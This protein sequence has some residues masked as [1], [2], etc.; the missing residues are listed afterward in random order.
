M[1]FC[2]HPGD[3]DRLQAPPG[4]HTPSTHAE[5]AWYL[6]QRDTRRA[7]AHVALA[8]QALREVRDSPGALTERLLARLRLVEAEARWLFCEPGAFDLAGEAFERCA[9][10]GDSI[11]CGDALL[12]QAL[13]HYDNVDT[14]VRAALFER[15]GAT[16]RAAGDSDRAELVTAWQ[17]YD[18]TYLDAAA[19][20]QALL[21]LA[22]TTQASHPGVRAVSAWAQAGIRFE[23]SDV[24]AAI[25]GYQN[26]LALMDDCGFQRC[27]IT[28]MHNIGAAF[29]TLHDYAAALVWFKR[30]SERAQR[31]GWPRSEG[32]CLMG[33]GNVLRLLGRHDAALAFLTRA[34]ERLARVPP[35]RMQA[36]LQRSLGDTHV[37][38]GD[39]EQ[40][41]RSFGQAE[42]LIRGIDGHSLL[43]QTLRGKALALSQTGRAV[44]ALDAAAE[45]LRI[46]RDLGDRARQIESLCALASI[47]RTHAWPAPLGSRDAT[48]AIHHLRRAIRLAARIE[49]H[50][51]PP[52][53]LAALSRDQ[54]LAGDIAAALATERQASVARRLTASRE[55]AQSAVAMQIR[56]ETDIARADAQHQRALA[57]AE[58]E[59]VAQLNAANDLL[60]RVSQLG[61]AITRSLSTDSLLEVLTHRA[62]EL[63]PAQSVSLWVLQEAVIE[64]QVAAGAAPRRFPLDGDSAI[65][66]CVRESGTGTVQRA[67][68]LG[69][70][71]SS[72]LLAPLLNGHNLRGV[73]AIETSAC[74]AYAERDLHVAASLA[75][76]VTIALANALA[77]AAVAHFAR[78]DKLTSIANRR[79]FDE[80]LATEVV[81]MRRNGRPLS[82]VLVDV[83]HFKA[84]NDSYGH[85]QG[86]E[87]LR[88]IGACLAA[89]SRVG[90][91]L[92]ARYGGEEFALVL[93]DTGAPEALA[94]AERLRLRV[95]ALC[96]PHA[97][98][99]VGAFVSL[100]AGVA[101]WLPESPGGVAALIAA[102][103]RALYDAKHRGRDRCCVDCS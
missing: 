48:A 101:T 50:V 7:L 99:S 35:G 43:G 19:I 74:E 32:T 41:L 25:R 11:G 89:V 16:F 21:V 97:A 72:S 92:A 56:L 80:S 42:A 95:G 26:A 94:I 58:A 2:G 5:L 57:R 3:I 23:H 66:R 64:E 81:R 31:T 13:I 98:S 67:G 45:A 34:A 96:L 60:A 102:A 40:A 46:A 52:E 88:Q 44:E 30:A 14:S 84:Y 8:R 54:E 47:A 10:C 28:V 12:L 82:L 79:C 15:A 1:D 18:A 73:L 65:A 77:H 70:A 63:L 27:A 61:Q 9:G 76:Y 75:S 78:T 36:T 100:S 83:D 38:R 33:V 51:M 20:T 103:D 49:G 22:R 53:D 87:C 59:R 62:G 37:A 39:A 4:G 55:A 6:R 91:D 68:G 69:G 29:D 93:P 85:P 24:P 90:C 17:A 86:D 71:M